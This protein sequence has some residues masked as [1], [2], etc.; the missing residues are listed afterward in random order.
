MNGRTSKSAW[1]RREPPLETN[2]AFDRAWAE[3]RAMLLEQA[4]DLALETDVQ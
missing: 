1:P 3:G 4:M 2:A